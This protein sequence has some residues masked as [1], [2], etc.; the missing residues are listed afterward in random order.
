MA[1]SDEDSKTRVCPFC[2]GSGRCER[3]GGSGTRIVRKH[4][5][6]HDQTPTCTVCDGSGECQLCRGKGTLEA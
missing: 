4:W 1:P 2:G 5:P 6:R 3:C